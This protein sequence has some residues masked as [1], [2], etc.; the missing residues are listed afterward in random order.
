MFLN[1]AGEV[2]LFLRDDKAHIPYPNRWDTLGGM[3]EP[4]ETPEECIVREIREEI[5]FEVQTP[6]LFKVHEGQEG[7]IYMFWQR[8][9]IDIARTPLHEGQRL[10]WFSRQEIERMPTDE[11]AFGFRELLLEFYDAVT[12]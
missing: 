1:A 9:E 3:I 11:F 8:A 6:S 5:E 2:L 7:A 12:A 4:G 10:K